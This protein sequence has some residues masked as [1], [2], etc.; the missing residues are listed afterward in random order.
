MT[1]SLDSDRDLDPDDLAAKGVSWDLLPLLNGAP[2]VDSLI[3]AADVIAAELVEMGRGRVAMM[4]AARL[5]AF[6]CRYAELIE[7]LGRASNFASLMF[8]G[9]TSDPANGA[10]VAHVQ[11]RATVISTQLL[12]IELE[13]AAATDEH[14]D[15]IL[16]APDH[17]LDFIRHRLRSARRYR[18]HLL[19]EPEERVI[20]E[21]DV[22]GESAWTR[23]FEELTSVL[24]IT[25]DQPA[26][27]ATVPLMQGLSMLQHPDRAVRQSAHVAV[28]V[29]LQPGLRTRAFVFNTLLNN[30]SVE[31]RLR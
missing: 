6:H 2:D 20:T 23:L 27:P 10:L 11:E 29:G 9:D 4:T 24:E 14:V 22:T 12:F 18:P 8:A 31:D 30:K 3:D 16:S 17:E 13:W 19:T 25:V 7:L 5:G 15:E 28:S 26:G 1:S 21:K